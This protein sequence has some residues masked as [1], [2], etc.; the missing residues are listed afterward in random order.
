MKKIR[1]LCVL[2]IFV[3]AM[4]GC[5]SQVSVLQLNKQGEFK[6]IQE[7]QVS[8][9]DALYL[10]SNALG[11]RLLQ[12]I[13]EEKQK[14]NIILSPTSLS[15]VLAVLGNGAADETRAEINGLIDPEGF[16][17]EELNEKYCNLI[18]H[19]NN[20]GYKEGEKRTTLVEL[21]NS[22][23]MEER[24]P[25]KDAFLRTANEYY[26]TEVYN[27]NFAE[28]GTKN[29]IN[30][31]IEGKTHNR[32]RNHI[33]D[34]DPQTAMY[35]FNSLYFQGKWQNKFDKS[36]TQKEDFELRN[37]DKVTVDMMNA[38]RRISYYEDDKIQAGKFD[39]YG[40]SMLVILPKGNIDGYISQLSNGELDKIDDSFDHIKVKIKLPKFSFGQKNQLN[41]YL[42]ALGMKT[43]FDIEKADFTGIADRSDG[44][45]LYIDDIAQECFISVD[46][47][48][49]EAAALTSVLLAGA[50]PPKEIVPPEFYVERPFLFIIRDNR[51]GL[52]LFMGKVENPLD[53]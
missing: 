7:P 46:E 31:W 4:T 12:E 48:G 8:N 29:A 2:L 36:E 52:M 16:L 45:N 26:N 33:A 34:I 19:L 47:E 15:T 23:W 14:E 32:I 50:A 42:T 51:T 25:V 1:L 10:A 35:I 41:D 5:K 40:C 21:A 6:K 20:A 43:A 53:N 39:Y 30:Q 49:T 44:F 38:E 18:N 3:L 27:V 22:I 13:S 24:L 28:D 37:G 17:P 9:K 11:I